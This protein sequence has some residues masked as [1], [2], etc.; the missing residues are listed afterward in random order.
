MI[1]SKGK[2]SV[3]NEK[4]IWFAILRSHCPARTSDG[5]RP[6]KA[7]GRMQINHSN[8]GEGFNQGSNHGLV[9]TRITKEAFVK[10]DSSDFVAGGFA[11]FRQVG[12]VVLVF[13]P[14][15]S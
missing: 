10:Q 5:R 15:L 1:K 9:F 13:A 3:G 2:T 7:K 11:I 14:I 12:N 6:R 4:C 8:F